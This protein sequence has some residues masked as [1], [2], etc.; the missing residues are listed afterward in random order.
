MSKRVLVVEDDESV[1][2]LVTIVLEQAGFVTECT[3]DGAEVVELVDAGAFDLVVLDLMLPTINGF[4]VCRRVR[5]RSSVPIVML[6]ARTDTPDIV[7]GLELGA[8]DYVTKPFEPAELTARARAAVRR[9]VEVHP[10][11]WRIRDLDI[12]EAAFRVVRGCEEIALSATEFRLLAVLASHPGQV[13]TREALLERVWGYDYLGDSR[14]VDMAILRLRAKLGDP[15]E[16][17]PYIQTVRSMG[18]RF[19]DG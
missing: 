5:E 13:L 4:E 12:D 2:A 16:P 14:L 8:D 15:D 18:Y 9:S 10:P 7:R 19:E 1:R 17:P 6:T 11:R 3:D